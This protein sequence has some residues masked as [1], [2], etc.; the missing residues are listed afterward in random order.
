MF[1]VIS[2]HLESLKESKKGC[3]IWPDQHLHAIGKITL[4][5]LNLRSD[6]N[7]GLSYETCT[8]ASLFCQGIYL[9]KRQAFMLE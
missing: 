7:A 2:L 1:K 4:P 9:Y 6:F 8:C 3:G 5:N